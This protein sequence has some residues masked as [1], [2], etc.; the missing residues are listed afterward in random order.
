[1]LDAMLAQSF[2]VG[3]RLGQVLR[4][5][6]RELLFFLSQLKALRLVASED[7]FPLGLEFRD[8]RRVTL[9]KLTNELL[10]G[11]RHALPGLGDSGPMPLARRRSFGSPPRSQV[12]EPSNELALPFCR[13]GLPGHAVVALRLLARIIQIAR[14][15]FNCSRQNLHS[16]R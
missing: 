3:K 5:F 6:R 1:L 13:D 10:A 11:L 2:R 7:R 4:G 14:R 12:R 8:E 9:L 16:G 15:L